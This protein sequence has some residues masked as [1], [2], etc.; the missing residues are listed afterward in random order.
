LLYNGKIVK[1][2][3]PCENLYL[4]FKKDKSQKERKL[5]SILTYIKW[6]II[7]RGVSIV[8][9]M[10]VRISK[11]YSNHIWTQEKDMKSIDNNTKTIKVSNR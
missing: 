8:I 7:G 11:K 6:K 1:T 2:E 4:K 5:H 10:D 9:K 3:E